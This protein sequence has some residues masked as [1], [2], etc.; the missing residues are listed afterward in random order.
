MN[1]YDEIDPL[2]FAFKYRW[3]LPVVMAATVKN[4]YDA[5]R[6]ARTLGTNHKQHNAIRNTNH[7]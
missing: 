3:H 2:K 6:N 7:R 1:P 4:N 5:A